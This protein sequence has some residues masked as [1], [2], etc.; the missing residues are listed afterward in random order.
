[1]SKVRTGDIASRGSRCCS[2]AVRDAGAIAF[3]PSPA[4]LFLLLLLLRCCCRVSARP[5]S[6]PSPPP[7][8]EAPVGT[9]FARVAATACCGRAGGLRTPRCI[10]TATRSRQ[11]SKQVAEV[12]APSCSRKVAASVVHGRAASEAFTGRPWIRSASRARSCASWSPS[13]RSASSSRRWSSS[14]RSSCRIRASPLLWSPSPSPSRRSSSA[15]CR[16][17]E[18]T[19]S[20]KRAMYLVLAASPPPNDSADGDGDA[21]ARPRFIP[22]ADATSSLIDGD[23][24]RVD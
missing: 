18:A 17:R 1:M 16:R 4:S 21:A 22:A 15:A 19:R 20:S 23:V 5:P 7:L 13:C 24:E 8:A 14:S 11:A 2:V 12:P 10:S 6:P 3:T 9:V